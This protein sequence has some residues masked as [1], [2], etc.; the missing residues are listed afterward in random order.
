M[1]G[2]EAVE[3][4]DGWAQIAQKLDTGLDDVGTRAQ[5][6]PVGESV[7]A[8]IGLG[9][10]GELVVRREV[11]ASAVDDGSADDR[12][13]AVEE[14]RDR[15]DDDV[16]AMS[17][18]VD[19]VR[20]ADR[21]V[22]DQ[23]DTV[24]VGNGGDC[25]DVEYVVARVADALAVERFGIGP[26]C[27][28]PLVRIPRIIDEGDLETQLGEGV[29]EQVVGTAIERGRCNDVIAGLGEVEDRKRLGRES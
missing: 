18:R 11:K 5:G 15:V 8:G 29:V 12:V 28:G 6:R 2:K 21:V 1:D 7:V 24:G 4:R 13:V 25:L 3:R 17:E 10:L 23:R 9:E 22:D 26:D 16:R 27:I 19:Q 20:G 14:L